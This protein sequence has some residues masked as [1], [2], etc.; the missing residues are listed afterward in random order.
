MQ[1]LPRSSLSAPP[2]LSS[3]S[4][5]SPFR[6]AYDSRITLNSTTALSPPPIP[7]SESEKYWKGVYNG[8][9]GLIL[10]T[11]VEDAEKKEVG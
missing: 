11:E 10:A 2:F 5:L 7:F 4:S 1:P 8:K 9:P 6:T 3:H